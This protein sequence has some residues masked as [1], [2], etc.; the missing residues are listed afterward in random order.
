[1]KHE[2]KVLKSLLRG[3]EPEQRILVGYQGEKQE[4]EENRL[5][6]IM[7]GVR[8]PWFCPNCDKIMKN[9]H[10]RKYWMRHQHC[11]D[12]QIK[13]ETKMRIDGTWEK[14]EANKL[15]ED[16]KSYVKDL[17]E[18]LKGYIEML[19]KKQEYLDEVGKEDNITVMKERWS[20][21]D[22]TQMVEGLE[23]EIKNIEK[24]LSGEIDWNELSGENGQQS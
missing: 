19:T 13:L 23:K 15:D 3:E 8:M 5:T 11:M 9:R 12:C 21:G 7:K 14:H 18:E 24:Y 20:M 4:R 17:K 2:D 16:R 10:D 22:P 6:D 1:M